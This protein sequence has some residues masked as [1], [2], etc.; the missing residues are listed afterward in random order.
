M[1]VACGRT[2]HHAGEYVVPLSLSRIC[3][4][5]DLRLPTRPCLSKAPPPPNSAMMEEQT[6]LNAGPFGKHARSKLS[7]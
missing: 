7:W 6:F 5:I 3:P 2:A 4:P 1:A